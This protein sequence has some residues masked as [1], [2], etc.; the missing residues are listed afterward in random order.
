MTENIDI[1]KTRTL[2]A[3]KEFEAILLPTLVLESEFQVV[4]SSPLTENTSKQ[5]KELQQKYGKIRTGL[6]SVHKAHKAFFLNGGRAIDDLKKIYTQVV[7]AKE[8]TLLVIANHF[9]NLENEKLIALQ[10]KRLKQL[11][12]FEPEYIPPQYRRDDRIGL[13][14][15]SYRS[16]S[17][18]RG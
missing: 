10:E 14:A 17:G 6:A 5:A 9:I 18:L 11:E 4:Q 15:I 2:E 1:V 13:A 16:R 12:P 8:T 3:K 7:E